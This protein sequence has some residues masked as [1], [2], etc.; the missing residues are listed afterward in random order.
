MEADICRGREPEDIARQENL[1]ELLDGMHQFVDERTEEEGGDRVLM[2]HYL[3]EVSLLS[4]LD[5]SDEDGD[6]KLSLMTVHSA[7]G[8]EFRVVFVVGMEENL[9]PNQMSMNS[10]RELEEERRLFYVAITRAEEQC[11]LTYA[12]NRYR[13]GKSEFCTRSNFLNE[14]D[15]QYV[16]FN[17]S[18]G[19]S[20][21]SSASS[22]SMF[23]SF[24]SSSRSSGGSDRSSDLRPSSMPLRSLKRVSPSAGESGESAASAAVSSTQTAAGTL[25]VGSRIEHARFGCGTVTALSGTG[26][27]A[28]A[29]VQF[30]N[31]GTKQLL[32]RFAK[33]NIL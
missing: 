26:I 30:D 6:D 12:Q 24:E 31:V 9:F 32:L 21:R 16:E 33:F 29:T 25:T 22:R 28:K 4:D 18:S 19:S 3:Q 10:V 27:D 11:F 5:E 8:L 23:G 20:S 14:I 1:Q 7:K 13:F 17:A 2:T 15:P